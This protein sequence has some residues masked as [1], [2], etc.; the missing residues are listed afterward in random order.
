MSIHI[1]EKIRKRAKE[2]RIG[3]TELGKLI[4]TS[5]QNVM[6]IYTRRSIDAELLYKLSKALDHDFFQYYQALAP[7]QFS[8]TGNEYKKATKNLLNVR[9]SNLQKE[10]AILNKK[11]GEKDT[12]IVKLQKK[13]I[14]LL[15][16][17]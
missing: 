5:K 12:E 16:R 17:K 14:E 8:E 4:H 10:L 6:G 3:P 7:E 2:L 9:I 13:L 11:L 1:G 15:E